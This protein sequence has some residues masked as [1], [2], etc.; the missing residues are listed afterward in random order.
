LVETEVLQQ[1]VVEQGKVASR[2]LVF[3]PAA[4]PDCEAGP[5]RQ[6]TR[7]CAFGA[8]G[9]QSTHA[10]GCESHT[11]G[12]KLTALPGL[13]ASEFFVMTIT[14]PTK[15][16]A[17]TNSNTMDCANH[18][19]AAAP[20][21]GERAQLNAGAVTVWKS[22]VGSALSKCMES[23]SCESGA[24]LSAGALVFQ[25]RDVVLRRL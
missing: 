21:V 10:G 5:N 16:T 18:R 11:A 23:S 17:P 4:Q 1:S 6:T 24:R 9:H 2:A 19:H 3:A 20:A 7:L 25:G 8:A 12:G 14:A 15:I 13:A 22:L